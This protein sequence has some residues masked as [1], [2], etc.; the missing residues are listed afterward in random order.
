MFKRGIFPLAVHNPQYG[1]F[2]TALFYFTPVRFF[3]V[4]GYINSTHTYKSSPYSGKSRRPYFLYKYAPSVILCIISRFLF[5]SSP[6]AAPKLPPQTQGRS[7]TALSLTRLVPILPSQP[8]R[9][10]QIP[11]LKSGKPR[12]VPNFSVR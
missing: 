10:P 4:T 5:Y 11:Y 3:L 7:Q 9:K 2:N 1:K 8:K 6:E 12:Q